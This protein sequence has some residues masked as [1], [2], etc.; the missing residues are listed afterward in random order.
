MKE[1]LLVSLTATAI[2]S[3]EAVQAQTLVTLNPQATNG[4]VGAIDLTE[5]HF[6]T[7][8]FLASL[9][10]TT[11]IS[12]TTGV[13]TFTQTGLLRV[14]DFTLAGSNL[15]TNANDTY[16][17][18]IDYSLSG[19]GTW[20]SSSKF[21]LSSAGALFSLS[22]GADT[23]MDT[24]VDINLATGSLD[25]TYPLIA[26]AMYFAPSFALTSLTATIDLTPMAGTTGV[27]GFFEAP[28]P[29]SIDIFAGNVGGS[30]NDTTYVINGNGSISMTTVGGSG[31]FDFVQQVP[32]PGTSALLGIAL[33]GM[34]VSRR[35]K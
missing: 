7:D 13:Q 22:M 26:Y 29:F 19:S 32:E 5:A 17:I 28:S 3:S 4:G 30:F 34:C 25:S 20:T 16:D 35:R 11:L 21:D 2:F 8:G 14:T 10:S 18:F 1:I 27:D 23:N 9:G 24:V 12:G 33:L 31:N 6:D 15:N